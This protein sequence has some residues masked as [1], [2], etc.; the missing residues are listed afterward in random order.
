MAQ[1]T[2]N[3]VR[4]AIRKALLEIELSDFSL[5]DNLNLYRGEK[6]LY[7]PDSKNDLIRF[8]AFN[9]PALVAHFGL[10][11]AP[12]KRSSSNLNSKLLSR[13]VFTQAEMVKLGG[14]YHLEHGLLMMIPVDKIDGLDPAPGSW[15]DDE[16][17]EYEFQKGVDLFDAKP[18]EVH[19]DSDQDLFMLYDGNHRVTQ[20]KLNQDQYIK[21]LVQATKQDYQR[22]LQK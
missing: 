22:W 12:A 18:I 17:N 13:Q 19:Y 2:V 4:R 21:A 15:S 7:S 10:D 5:D 1:G 9:I 16:G 20:A 8:L 14:N 11:Q 6:R 3:E